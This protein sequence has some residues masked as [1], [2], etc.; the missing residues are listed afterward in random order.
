VC[1]YECIYVCILLIVL[2]GRPIGS[3]RPTLCMRLRLSI[4][5]TQ[6]FGPIL[7][8]MEVSSVEDA[9]AFVNANDKP[10]AL[11]VFSNEPKVCDKFIGSTSS[12]SALQND[13]LMQGIVMRLLGHCGGMSSPRARASL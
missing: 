13:C 12:G 10:L 5:N 9:V 4:P 11:Y 7:P 6:I 2:T 1:M 3:S 8:I